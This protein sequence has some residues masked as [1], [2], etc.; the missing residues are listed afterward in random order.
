MTMNTLEFWW[1]C[2]ESGRQCDGD[3]PFKDDDV[4]LHYCANGA[5]AMV[6][7]GQLRAALS[8]APP[9]EPVGCEWLTGWVFEPCSYQ[10]RNIERYIGAPS[11]NGITV[12][13]RGTL[14]ERVLFEL[15]GY[16]IGNTAPVQSAVTDGWKEAAIAWNVCA[17]IHREY[18][19]GKDALFTTRQADFIRHHEAA[20]EKALRPAAMPDEGKHRAGPP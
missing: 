3:P 11:G 6:T 16:A 2:V 12:A 7:A 17:S 9:A 4:I 1:A 5:T 18:A 19:K 10:G 13:D 20:R 8:A 14:A 15:A